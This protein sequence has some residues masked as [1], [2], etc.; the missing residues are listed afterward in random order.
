MK[1]NCR[2]SR[3]A[4]GPPL[5]AGGHV[6]DAWLLLAADGELTASEA[7]VVNTHLEA[8]WR[9]RVRK[10]EIER[11][12]GNIVDYEKLFVSA[13][14]Q[15]R[16][17]GA[18]LFL[19]RL[20]QL[21]TELGHTAP[22]RQQRL[23]RMLRG[24]MSSPLMY[25]ASIL[26]VF[27][28]LIYV[29]FLRKT[30]A[31]SASE[32]LHRATSSEMT[33]FHQLS[34]P[35][36]IQRVKVKVGQESDIRTLYRDVAHGREVQRVDSAVEN[37]KTVYQKFQKSS[38]SWSDPLSPEKYRD[39]RASVDGRQD[40]VTR[41]D[42]NLI[43]L[44]TTAATGPIAEA[45]LIVRSDD[46]HPVAE[47]LRLRD[48]TRIEVAELSYDVVGLSTVAPSIFEPALPKV[49]AKTVVPSIVPLAFASASH[50]QPF[51]LAASE[52]AIASALHSVGADLGEQISVQP[53][54]DGLIQ[55][56]G[57]A[58]SS[59]RQQEIANA[60]VAIPFTKVHIQ[61]VDD[62]PA[63]SSVDAP[64][65]QPQGNAVSI[66]EAMPP[67][68]EKQL[69]SR[70]ADPAIRNQY[71]NNTLALCQDASA[72]TWALMRLAKQFDAKKIGLL[73]ANAQVQLQG[74][75]SDHIV[76]IHEDI[77]ELRAQLNPIVPNMASAVVS[78]AGTSFSNS[79]ESSWQDSVNMAHLSAQSVSASVESLLAGSAAEEV[80]SAPSEEN[81][82]SAEILQFQANMDLLGQQVHSI[83]R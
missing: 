52:L 73:D 33:A 68:L 55:V 66:T 38:L 15:P 13:V 50:P 30:P 61:S 12:I 28:G 83:S 9:C 59:V 80:T 77:N 39:W 76:A 29:S 36:V 35:V 4:S 64:P 74:I 5:K 69:D 48:N 11:T 26:L 53:N 44:D 46:Y 37:D 70:F 79:P 63:Q 58:D 47:D 51:Q 3:A 49:V 45:A 31:V 19:A 25:T 57:L 23:L 20:N 10:E 2:N 67:L 62:M 14:V 22:S 40:V 78:V 18:S 27:V 16:S 21:A 6:K 8:C 17:N 1:K 34:Q 7:V 72:H 54:I 24:M 71:V 32:I 56:N 65:E 75:L 81:K 42:G 41:L 43:R 82:L 60:L